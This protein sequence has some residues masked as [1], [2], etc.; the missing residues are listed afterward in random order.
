MHHAESR[1]SDD[2]CAFAQHQCSQWHWHSASA[3]YNADYN[4]PGPQG[5]YDPSFERDACGVG[6]VAHLHGQPSHEIVQQGLDI[7]KN[8][9]HRGACGCD[10][11]TGDGAGILVQIPDAFFRR[12]SQEGAL[13]EHQRRHTGGLFTSKSSAFELPERGNYGVGMVFMPTNPK[14]QFR[15][16]AIVNAQLRSEGLTVLGWRDVPTNANAI[17]DNA[18]ATQPSVRQVFVSAPHLTQEQLEI[19]LFVVRRMASK[20]IARLGLPQGSYFY[21]PSFSTKT[22]CYKGLLLPEQMDKFYTDLSEDDFSSAFALVHQRFSTNTFPSWKLAHP[23][24]YIAHNGEINTLR[25]N[26]NWMYANEYLLESPKFGADISK[27]KPIVVEGGSDSG[28]LDNMLELLVLGGRSLPHALMMLVPEA[29]ESKPNMSNELRGFYRYHAT[30]MEPWDGPAAI[31]FTDGTRI[32]AMLDRNGLRPARYMITKDDVVILASESG[33]LPIPPERVIRRGRVE[34]GS[35]MLIDPEQ[36]RIIENDELKAQIAAQQPYSAWIENNII[37]L[38]ETP[39]LSEEQHQE[40]A[41]LYLFD[42]HELLEQQQAFGYTDEDIKIIVQPMMESGEEPVGS[43]GTDTPL[44]VLS[45]KPQLFFHYFKQLF[46]QVTNPPIDPLREKLVMSLNVY[47]GRR[48][49]LLLE[50]DDHCRYVLQLSSPVVDSAEL[51][52]VRCLAQHPAYRHFTT[53]TLSTLYEIA[54]GEQGLET[55]LDDLCKQAE[56][57]LDEGHSLII[58]SDRGVN[59]TM[60]PMP[61]LLATSAVHHHLIRVGKRTKCGIIVESGE[62]REV[63]HFA[64]LIG[65]GASAVNPYLAFG[66]IDELVTREYERKHGEAI[67]GS[68]AHDPRTARHIEEAHHNYV[69]AVE[70]GLLKIFS[71]MGISTIASYRGAQMFEAVGVSRRIID[72]YMPRTSSKIDG[73]DMRSI[74]QDVAA[75]HRQAFPE[76]RIGKPALVRSGQYQW[77][78]DGEFHAYNPATI[79]KLQVATKHGDYAAFKEYSALVNERTKRHA[80]LRGLLELKQTASI[81]L[82]EVEPIENIMKR[83][84]TGAMSF[85]SISKE[86]HE[87]LAIAMNAIGGKSNTGEGGEDPERFRDHRRSAIKQVASGRFGVTSHYLINADELQI[88]IAQGAKPGEGGQL[89]GHKVDAAIARVRHSLPGV[90]LISPPPHHDIYSIEDLAQLIFDLK[91]ANPR[92]QVSVKLVSEAGVGVVAAGVAKAHADMILIS[93]YDGGTGA[94]PVSSVRHAGIPWE[95]GLAET[96]QVLVLNELRGRVRVQVDGQMKTGRDVIIAALLGAEEFGFS[97]AALV[98]EGCIL[99]RKCH[100]N[101]CPVGIATQRPELRAKFTGKPDY[102]I[103]F[104]RFVAEEVREIMADLGARTLDELIGRSDLLKAAATDH[105]KAALLDIDAMLYKPKNADR[106]P[107]R[108]VSAQDHELHTALDNELIEACKPALETN[109]L[110]RERVERRLPIAN[111]HRSVGTMLG[112]EVS[113]RFGEKGLPDDTICLTFHG[114]AGQ[115]FGA[116]IPRGITLRLEGDANDYVGK[117]LSGGTIIVRPSHNGSYKAEE[118]VIAGNTCLYGAT[119]GRAF[120]RGKAGERFAVR[121]SGAHAVVEGVG[122]HGCEYMTGGIVVVLGKTGRNFAAGMSGGLAFV[123]DPERTFATCCNHEMVDVL[124]LSSVEDHGIRQHLWDM[125]QQHITHTDS[126]VAKR[127]VEQWDSAVQDI[128]LVFPHEYRRYLQAQKIKQEQPEILMAH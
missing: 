63:M 90:T 64:L 80:T 108:C 82:H 124:N 100:L 85:G 13:L 9:K 17:G 89:P 45:D 60:A 38:A 118:N 95:L 113:R 50:Q 98:A 24:R 18:R 102:V 21:I 67:E 56:T 109:D 47:T 44:A 87:T 30:L 86:A 54:S 55:A 40:Y 4:I 71:K 31:A 7:L 29:Y 77:Q 101:T 42:R 51:E 2:Q 19:K 111:K 32:G 122:D 36:G 76:R 106:S 48:G 1:S 107:I 28:I 97:T 74:A 96:Q 70:K 25:G 5:L 123:Y 125:L 8:L 61:S 88:K 23:Y 58:L 15:C 127:I 126:S 11:Q 52:Q 66:T 33:V 62:P 14:E 57:A 26:I 119:S 112:S 53:T 116:F 94:S 84:A 78:R 6:F 27:I 121:N 99:M 65:Y 92:A 117:G 128:A 69:K 16:E 39:P 93:G 59:R 10:P 115:S 75:R 43:M 103:N 68:A 114:T 81:P 83:F 72:K 41:S 46:A 120:L 104:F 20:E 12:I 37:R 22:V 105:E 35:M 91:N 34:P 73:I 3:D 110:R 49:S 79:H